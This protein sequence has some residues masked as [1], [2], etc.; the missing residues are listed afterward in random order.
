MKVS[1]IWERLLIQSY[2]DLDDNRGSI[3]HS[4]SHRRDDVGNLERD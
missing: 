2:N 1:E 3:D 4:H